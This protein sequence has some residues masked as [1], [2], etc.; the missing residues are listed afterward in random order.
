MQHFQV[1]RFQNEKRESAQFLHADIQKKFKT[2][3]FKQTHFILT[4]SYKH[5]WVVMYYVDLQK[6]K[7]PA[8][9]Y[10]HFPSPPQKKKN[11]FD[12]N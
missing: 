11:F 7:L 8:A 3:K 1:K 6:Y 9:Y 4:K 10:H 2:N 12:K 5:I